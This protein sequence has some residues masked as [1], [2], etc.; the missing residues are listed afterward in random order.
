[1]EETS[2]C[3]IATSIV[4]K[5]SADLETDMINPADISTLRELI[6]EHVKRSLTEFETRIR[7]EMDKKE[8]KINSKCFDTDTRLDSLETT[9]Q[10]INRSLIDLNTKTDTL[11]HKPPGTPTT[12]A[13][14]ESQEMY[15]RRNNIRIYGIPETDEEDTT[16]LF[17]TMANDKLEVDYLSDR[18]VCRSHRIGKLKPGVNSKPRPIIVRQLITVTRSA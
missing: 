18:D 17:L 14:N 3:P 4:T 10:S 11:S 1:M 8:D 2:D 9:L 6:C 16:A 7:I 13:T 12:M 5:L 15:S